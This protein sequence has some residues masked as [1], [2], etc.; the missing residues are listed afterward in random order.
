LI[1]GTGSHWQV[2][3]PVLDTLAVRHDVIAV[4]LSGHGGSEP[5][6]DGTPPTAAGFA[7]LISTFLREELGIESAHV[8]GNSMG[9][10]TALEMA[11][12]GH[13][14]S[15][16]ALCPAG[17][18]RTR[19][20]RYCIVSFRFSCAL[21]HLL[22]RSGARLATSTAAGRTIVMSQYFGRP[23]K[24]PAGEAAELQSG[25]AKGSYN[26]AFGEEVSRK[27]GKKTWRRSTE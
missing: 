24:I 13:A 26:P 25:N 12:L 8:A 22:G 11:K 16:T 14:R 7:R 23:W 19:T 6:P 27:G 17:L 3:E 15:L 4:D 1:H 18:W 5:A 21:S 9:G 2:W 10:W 20:P